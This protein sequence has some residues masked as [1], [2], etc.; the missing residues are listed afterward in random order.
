[1]SLNLE[2]LFLFT[3]LSLP[4]ASLIFSLVRTNYFCAV[5]FFVSAVFVC[6][7]QLYSGGDTLAESAVAGL[8]AIG[9]VCAYIFGLRM[10]FRL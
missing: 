3:L 6:F 5:A 4:I 1:M 2:Y 10:L 7:Y 8:F 9:A